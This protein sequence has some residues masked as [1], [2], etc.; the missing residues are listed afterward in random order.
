MD[1]LT[2]LQ[3][4]STLERLRA[5]EL[6]VAIDTNAADGGNAPQDVIRRRTD[7]AVRIFCAIYTQ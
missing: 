3:V 4:H 2:A 6:A 7:N 5:I 1:P